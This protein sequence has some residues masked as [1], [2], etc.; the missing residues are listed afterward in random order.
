MQA[1]FARRTGMWLIR[2]CVC[3]LAAGLILAPTLLE[4]QLINV[5]QPLR[6]SSGSYFNR[7]AVPF[8]F[9][10]R[11]NSRIRGLN[12][13]G[14]ITP[15]INFTQNSAAST[16]P[17]FGGYDPNAALRTGVAVIGGDASFSL[18]LVAG[19]GNTRSLV[20]T[21]PSVTMFNGQSA[22]IFSGETRPFVTGITPVVGNSTGVGL[23]Q[24]LSLPAGYQ[25]SALPRRP[26]NTSPQTYG[27]PHSTATRAARS[28]VEIARIKAHAEL[29]QQEQVSAEI[30]D[31]VTTARRLADEDKFGAARVK[32][33][34]AIRLLESTTGTSELKTALASELEAIRDK[35]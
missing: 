15:N 21:T 30:Q 28:L 16:I 9:S 20:S 19:K 23:T 14:Q 27:D 3:G 32:F 24:P 26:V 6:T 10:F 7:T 34:R 33:S 25:P 5:R 17:P 29:Q 22:S 4:S 18:G 12:A 1:L 2:V 35:R 31:L 8:S 11:G 13:A